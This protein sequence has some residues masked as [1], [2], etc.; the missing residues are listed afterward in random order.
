MTSSLVLGMYIHRM[1]ISQQCTARY[2]RKR[3]SILLRTNW[4]R[5]FQWRLRLIRTMPSVW[6]VIMSRTARLVGK[7][8][9][10][11]VKIF[12]TSRRRTVVLVSLWFGQ[13]LPKSTFLR[14][15]RYT[16]HWQLLK[17][18]WRLTTVSTLLLPCVMLMQLW[19]RVL[20][21]SWVLQTQLLIFLLCGNWQK[22]PR[23]LSQVR[24]S[25]LARLL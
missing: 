9:R 1:L 19:L 11:C 18:L 20:L 14:T 23:C 13:H 7:W 3:I 21:S 22:R 25:R 12:A 4:S 15:R 24:T 10:L 8:L 2:W 5:L 16:A 6:Q 17:R